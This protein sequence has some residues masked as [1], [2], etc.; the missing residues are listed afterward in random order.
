MY[1]NRSLFYPC[2]GFDIA[3]PLG[4]FTAVVDCF[5]FV[6]INEYSRRIPHVPF[7]KWKLLEERDTEMANVT[8]SVKT[9]IYRPAEFNRTVEVNFVT[10]DGETTFDTLF[11][12]EDSTNGLTVFFHRGDSRGEGGSD[13]F[14]LN[15]MTGEG[16]KCELLEKILRTLAAPGVI[17]TDGSNAIQQFAAYFRKLDA[18]QDPHKLLKSFRI[19]GRSL[20]P[21]GTLD[22]RNGQTIVW[23]AE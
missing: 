21:I 10:G 12:H 5:W 8:L 17:V 20:T 18:L 9:R 19:N 15:T 1:R 22:V 3:T 2:A 14:W 23:Q 6:D 13:V 11:C 4:A 16:E 7:P